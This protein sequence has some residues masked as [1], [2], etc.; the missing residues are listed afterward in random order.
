MDKSH[1][2]RYLLPGT[3]PFLGNMPQRIRLPLR[4][5]GDLAAHLGSRPARE[6]RSQYV[7]LDV[8]R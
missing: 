1:T 5:A 7:D 8:P 2:Y 6:E 3:P 4:A